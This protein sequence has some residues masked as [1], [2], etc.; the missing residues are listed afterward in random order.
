M[1]KR[2]VGKYFETESDVIPLSLSRTSG[3]EY[4]KGCWYTFV[5]SWNPEF[6]TVVDRISII[7]PQILYQSN[8]KRTRLMLCYFKSS[9]TVQKLLWICS[10]CN[11]VRYTERWLSWET[12]RRYIKSKKNKL[13]KHWRG[14][15]WDLNLRLAKE[16]TLLRSGKWKKSLRS[17]LLL[18]DA[19]N[20]NPSGI[21]ATP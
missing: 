5:L 6:D 12:N 14:M 8:N 10:F 18:L 9:N 1:N 4:Q 21:T 15:N 16:N 19:T 20:R 7:L 13:K 2:T 11:K 3:L 17:Q